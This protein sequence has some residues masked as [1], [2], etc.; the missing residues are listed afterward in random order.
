MTGR[1]I[2]GWAG[3]ALAAMFFLGTASDGFSIGHWLTVIALPIGW[4]AG[5]DRG[6]TRYWIL[7]WVLWLNMFG[8]VAVFYR[9]KTKAEA[10]TP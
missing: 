7:N 5:K 3:V 4:V 1:E 9:P 10:P 8:L 6:H 2:A